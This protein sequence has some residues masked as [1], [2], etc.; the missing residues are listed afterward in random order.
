MLVARSGDGEQRADED[1]SRGGSPSDGPKV[2]GTSESGCDLPVMVD[3]PEKWLVEAVTPEMVKRADD[4]SLTRPGDFAWVC[5]LLGSPDGIQA[6]IF[7]FVAP[8]K[9][10]GDLTAEQLL[11]RLV[12]GAEGDV[13][14]STTMSRMGLDIVISRPS[15]VSSE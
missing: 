8:P 7:L 12:R 5:S 4:K 2:I 13:S 10:A 6:P 1:R 14:V 9:V 3:V 15:G 11:Q